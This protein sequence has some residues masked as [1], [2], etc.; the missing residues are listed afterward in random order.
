MKPGPIFLTTLSCC[1]AACG[2][3]RESGPPIQTTVLVEGTHSWDGAD[4][5]YPDGDAQ[6]TVARILMK[7]GASLP[8]HCHPVPL[9]GEV[10][11]GPLEVRKENGESIV[12][13]AGS[14]LIEVSNQW[15]YGHAIDDVEILVV[16]AGAEGVP[17][18]VFRDGDPRWQAACR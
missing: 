17:V 14:G 18:T 6:L 9:A 8:M 11:R 16:Y 13:P 15:H 3:P 7:A 12:V 2:L 4:F 5:T 1:L 10:V